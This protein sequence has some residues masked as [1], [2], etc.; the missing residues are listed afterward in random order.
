MK[1]KPRFSHLNLMVLFLAGLG[2]S[3]TKTSPTSSNPDLNES[4]KAF[5]S[6]FSG[7]WKDEQSE[8]DYLYIGASKGVI[9]A[10]DLKSD[11]FFD[12]I[13]NVMKNGGYF[14]EDR[15]S[16]SLD[17]KRLLRQGEEKG[18]SYEVKYLRTTDVLPERCME[19]V[20]KT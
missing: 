19:M 6:K 12:L 9:C 3:G 2:C 10:G 1:I 8:K 7:Y 11:S 13:G 18:V 20:R 14:S 15:L 16:L 4:G 17:G 5:D